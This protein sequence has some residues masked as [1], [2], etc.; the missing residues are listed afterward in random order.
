MAQINSNKEYWFTMGNAAYM[1]AAYLD[2]KNVNVK[3]LFK[4]AWDNA[5]QADRINKNI[6]RREFMNG[7]E[8]AKRQYN[9]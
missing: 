3:Q 2:R 7:V 1:V 6:A 8:S 5:P 4:S 9:V